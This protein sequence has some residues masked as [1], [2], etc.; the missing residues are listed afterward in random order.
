[1]G[2]KREVIKKGNCNTFKINGVSDLLHRFNLLILSYSQINKLP[3]SIC[4]ICEMENT[5]QFSE[6]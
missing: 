1:M 5:F 4:K 6:L 2:W 3:G